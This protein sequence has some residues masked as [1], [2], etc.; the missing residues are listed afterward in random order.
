MNCGH[1]S[2]TYLFVGLEL[3]LDFL[4]VFLV[5]VPQV[6]VPSCAVAIIGVIFCADDPPRK[7]EERFENW[8]DEPWLRHKATEIS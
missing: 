3:R 2:C 1:I 4:H 7:G 5:Q 6:V 8:S